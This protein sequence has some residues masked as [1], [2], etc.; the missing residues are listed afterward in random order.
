MIQTPCLLI[1]GG[2]DESV[3]MESFIRSTEFLKTSTLRIV[4]NASHFPH[5]EQ[6]Q[7]VNDLL[8][9]FLGKSTNPSP[10][11]YFQIHGLLKN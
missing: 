6:A 1:T 4:D 5:Q 2:K 10:N 7:V 8:I 9:S 11:F 3:Q